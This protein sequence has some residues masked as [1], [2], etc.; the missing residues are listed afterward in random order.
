MKKIIVS[1]KYILGILL[2]ITFFISCNVQTGSVSLGDV[3]F[4][5]KIFGTYRWTTEGLSLINQENNI[6]P[7]QP[8]PLY[9]SEMIFN[10]DESG[11]LTSIN[12]QNT[13]SL[14]LV[15]TLQSDT[16]SAVYN[17]LTPTVMNSGSQIKNKRYLKIHL[18]E[19]TNIYFSEFSDST[20]I[21]EKSQAT[22]KVAQPSFI[23]PN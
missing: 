22:L 1:S 23:V 8:N 14:S 15:Y 4:T 5:S 10:I 2:L 20:N 13:V 17:I 11:V 19:N 7:Q 21:A 6:F 16:N 3:F 9:T 18:D 12:Q